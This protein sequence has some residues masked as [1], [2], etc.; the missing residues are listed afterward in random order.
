MTNDQI[1]A[2]LK[3]LTTEYNEPE[4]SVS[5]HALFC[6][7]FLLEDPQGIDF[8]VEFARWVYNCGILV[9]EEGISISDQGIETAR[10]MNGN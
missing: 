3:H 4:G 2:V 7:L 5:F 1:L 8:I 9:G 6:V 10:S